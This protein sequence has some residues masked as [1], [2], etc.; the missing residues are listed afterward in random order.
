MPKRSSR[1][2]LA[3]KQK[4]AMLQD[5][6]E[7]IPSTSRYNCQVQEYK[8]VQQV[9]FLSN[10]KDPVDLKDPE[11]GEILARSSRDVNKNK[12]RAT[13][14]K[15]IKLCDFNDQI[16]TGVNFKP[17]LTVFYDK[18]EVKKAKTASNSS[19]MIHNTRKLK[20]GNITVDKNIP[21]FHCDTCKSFFNEETIQ[22]HNCNRSGHQTKSKSRFKLCEKCTFYYKEATFGLHCCTSV[23]IGELKK[24]NYKSLNF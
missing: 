19:E 5:P 8:E 11:T 6:F 9:D 20:I 23:N 1:C 10:K 22:N 16:N 24:I 14:S 2:I 21:R 12:M 18:L 7:S 17:K 3:N 4:E 13:S 15:L